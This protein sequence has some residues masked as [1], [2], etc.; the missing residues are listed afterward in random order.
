M[1]QSRKVDLFI[2]GAAKAGT[3]AL[4]QNLSRLSQIHF[5]PIKEPHYF[6]GD[7]DISSFRKDFR[8]QI[9]MNFQKYF[10]GKP[11]A[12]KYQA[13]IRD[14]EVYQSLYRDAREGQM[15]AEAS[16]SYLWSKVAA[17]NIK[18]YNPDSRIVMV[19]RDPVERAFSHYLMDLRMGF[20]DKDFIS[21]IKDD[22][23]SK[24]R[25]WG[26]SSLY[27]DLGLYAQQVQRY[28]ELFPSNQILILLHDQLQSQPVY[29]AQ[30]L[31]RFIGLEDAEISLAERHNV[32]KVPRN[33]LAARIIRQPW[34]KKIS[35]SKKL[36]KLMPYAS[37]I[38]ASRT[39]PQIT[40]EEQEYAYSYFSKDI[41]VLEQ[42]LNLDLS[43]W[44]RK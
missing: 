34:L 11:L 30:N 31:S 44:K 1:E 33:K 35:R 16:A 32:A 19:L 42:M 40:E 26:N 18:A 37:K 14:L 43:H 4:W 5:C 25:L 38:L 6:S 29:V 23:Q 36:V 39:V 22:M 21:A 2:V 41:E 7:I 27:I 15:L 3:T 13:F 8:D 17:R 28:L 10:E 12:Q 9:Q 20:T 24:E